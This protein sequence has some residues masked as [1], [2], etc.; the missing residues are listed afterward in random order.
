M[1]RASS[2]SEAIIGRGTWKLLR[3]DMRPISRGLGPVAST[4]SSKDVVVAFDFK[5]AFMYC[6]DGA[7]FNMF[8]RMPLSACRLG[9][10]LGCGQLLA[11]GMA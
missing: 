9:V 6:T 7:F 11:A 1:R 10:G 8:D 3:S 5:A 2:F 4:L